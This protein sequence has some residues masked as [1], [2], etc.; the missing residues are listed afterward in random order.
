M[1]RKEYAENTQMTR[2]EHA[3]NIRKEHTND[4]QQRTR[5][6]HCTQRIRK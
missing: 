4:M 2:N 5:K 1:T 6:E 3:N